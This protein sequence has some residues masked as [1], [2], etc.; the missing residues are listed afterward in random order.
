MKRNQFLH[1]SWK[2]YPAS[3]KEALCRGRLISIRSLTTGNTNSDAVTDRA[4]KTNETNQANEIEINLEQDFRKLAIRVRNSTLVQI[5]RAGDLIEILPGDGGQVVLLAPNLHEDSSLA[6]VGRRG[7]FELA[8]QLGRWNLFIRSVREFFVSKDFLE[9]ATPSLVVCPGTE[10]SLDVYKT[11]HRQGTRF[12]E[13]YLPTSPELHLK[14]SLTLGFE[15]IFEIT[16]SYR[17]NE[18]TDRHQPEFWILEWYRA[19]RGPRS[20]EQDIEDLIFNLAACL[21]GVRRPKSVGRKSVAQ[22]FMETFSFELTPST[23]EGELRALA[24][25]RSIDIHSATSIDDLFFLLFYEIEQKMN[26]DELLFVVGY[27]PYQ[28]ALARIDEE[29]WAE[30]FEVYWQGYELANAFHELNDPAVQ[31]ERSKEDVLKKEI[32]KKEKIPLD[33]E[34]FEA[35]EAGLPPASGV[36]LGLERLFMAFYGIEKIQDVRLFPMRSK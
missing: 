13:Y 1:D 27:P 11:F 21:P 34:F 32:A 15:K 2:K 28:A 16:R 30:R 33:E 5:L 22:L 36:A 7:S 9:I 14:K 18:M 31:R 20:I 24:Q 4:E 23:S 12:Q 35:L 29:G 10:P 19:Y 3:Q 6:R 8:A 17:N 26:S 25:S